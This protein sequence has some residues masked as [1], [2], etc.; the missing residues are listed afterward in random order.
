VKIKGFLRSDEPANEG[1]TNPIDEGKKLHRLPIL[2]IY[3]INKLNKRDKEKFKAKQKL[4]IQKF[5]KKY[6]E[7]HGKK[8]SYKVISDALDMTEKTVGNYVRQLKR[9]G[10][11]GK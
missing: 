4:R 3:D 11:L 10:I 9:E 2:P 1:L 8:P 7:K 5:Y 6:L